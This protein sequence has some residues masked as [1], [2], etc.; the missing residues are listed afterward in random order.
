LIA[1]KFLYISFI[2]LKLQPS[3]M[4]KNKWAMQF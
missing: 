3:Y 2:S 1:S 4:L